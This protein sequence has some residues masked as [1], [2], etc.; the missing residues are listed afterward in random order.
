MQYPKPHFIIADAGEL[1]SVFARL[2]FERRLR[3]P[4]TAQDA[5]DGSAQA[6]ERIREIG[7][8]DS[9]LLATQLEMALR[10]PGADEIISEIHKAGKSVNRS[11]PAMQRREDDAPR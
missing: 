8:D 3:L 4:I 9:R 2:V 5:Y 1:P 7:C 11:P 10:P 6:V